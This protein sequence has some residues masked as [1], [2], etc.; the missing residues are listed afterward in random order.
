CD[1]LVNVCGLSTDSPTVGACNSAQSSAQAKGNTGAAADVFNHAMG[2]STYFA[3][4]DGS[5]S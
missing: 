4:V 1:N 5:G 3:A 2:F